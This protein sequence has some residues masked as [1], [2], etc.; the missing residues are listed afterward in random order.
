MGN[1]FDSIGGVCMPARAHSIPVVLVAF[2]GVTVL[3]G[4]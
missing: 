3:Q 2:G 4:G 1:C